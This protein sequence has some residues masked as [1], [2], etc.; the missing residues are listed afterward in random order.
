M[1]CSKKDYQRI[2]QIVRTNTNSAVLQS[3]RIMQQ[4]E[5]EDTVM[6]DH[7][8][9]HQKLLEAQ[10]LINEL[11]DNLLSEEETRYAYFSEETSE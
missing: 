6:R 1:K 2:L 3:D 4:I 10:T 11:N 5:F 8:L 7:V 9:L